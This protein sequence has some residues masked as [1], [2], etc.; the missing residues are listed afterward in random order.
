MIS[1]DTLREGMQ[2]PGIA[3]TVNEKIKLATMISDAG[4]KKALVSYPSAHE[5]EK[6]VTQEIVKRGIFKDVYGLGRTLKSDID[7]IYST[8]ANIS[9]H[10]PFIIKDINTI[11]ENIR[12]ASRLCRKLE[13]ALVDIDQYT[14][15]DLIKI[16]RLIHDSGADIIQIPDTKGITEPNKYGTIIKRIKNEVKTS[17]EI[18]CHNDYGYSIAN[19]IEGLKNGADYVDASV[20]GLGERNGI[21]DIAVISNY[22]NNLG[23]T[24]INM[25]KL[26][27]AYNFMHDLITEKA[28]QQFFYHNIPVFGKN[29]NYNTAGTHASYGNIFTGTDYSVNVYTGKA[30]IRN[31]LAI[32]NLNLSD[33][34]LNL[35]IKKIKDLSSD[36]GMMLSAEEII[37][38][39]GDLN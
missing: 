22:L 25:E 26:K 33:E 37:K 27:T 10:L 35:L 30:M 21:T 14:I 8:G 7:E 9:L 11:L 12:Y 32:N 2:A 5:S 6:Y 36:T 18:H 38:L 13:V 29:I 15:N 34:N 39:A 1:D 20:F 16:S 3:F 23:K 17:L 28:G 24:S 4:I 19:A 31:I